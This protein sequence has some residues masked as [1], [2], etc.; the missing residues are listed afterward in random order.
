MNNR[1][2]S[3][4]LALIPL[5]IAINI[6]GGQLITALKLPIYLDSIGTVL[7]GVLLGPWVGLITGV[8]TNVIWGVSGLAPTATPFAPVAGV[9]GLLAGFA[10]RMGAFR[11][12]SPRILSAVI[13]AVFVFALALFV[14]MFINGTP[15]EDGTF[16]VFPAMSDLFASNAIVFIIALI[17]GGA[18]GYYVIKNAG[19]AGLAGLLTG[20]VAAV[21]SAPIAAYVFGGVTGSGTDALVAAFRASGANIL[22]SAF[23]QGTVSDPFDKL[24]SFMVVWL[25][26]QSLPQRL[27]AR[28][29]ASQG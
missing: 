12:E 18:L 26:I 16:T 15:S 20:L 25:I 3:T 27:L 19:Y 6:A 10:G 13:G 8:L 28:F 9:I 1:L 2:N 29:E 11:K 17:A 23:A 5:A 21:V 7:T 24:T 22:A 4:A 14:L